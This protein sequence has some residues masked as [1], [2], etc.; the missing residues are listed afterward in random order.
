MTGDAVCLWLNGNHYTA[1]TGADGAARLET[2][3]GTPPQGAAI[4]IR[5]VAAHS[6]TNDFAL[7]SQ[8]PEGMDGRPGYILELRLPWEPT[9]VRPG[10]GTS[11]CLA[12]GVCD[13]DNTPEV[14][15]RVFPATF[16]PL[17]AGGLLTDYAAA[18]LTGE[19][20]I[21]FEL[22]DLR[23]EDRTMAL[24]T[25]SIIHARLV[26]GAPI[27]LT[28]LRVRVTALGDDG[29]PLATVPLAAVPGY[30]RQGNDWRSDPLEFNAGRARSAVPL[31]FTVAGN[32][33]GFQT[34]LIVK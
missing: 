2:Y 5:T 13:R 1:G 14:R 27:D 31:I 21:R 7:L 18:T 17:D 6:L 30:V 34:R 28:D 26:I 29:Q 25:D 9:R 12:L 10:I 19:N 24:G 32:E 16:K 33:V 22:A 11:I 4:A 15:Q 3:A 23:K 8:A 20:P